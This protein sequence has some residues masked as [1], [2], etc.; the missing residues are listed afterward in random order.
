MIARA[1]R[2]RAPIDACGIG[3]RLDV[4]DDAPY[5]DCAY[6]LQEY[7]GIARRKQ[8]EG[9]ATWPGRKQVWRRV[10]DGRMAGDVV[11]LDS[12]PS[13]EGCVPLLQPVMRHGHRTSPAD[14]L[15]ACRDLASD[16]LK[17]L[18]ESLRSLKPCTP[19]RVEIADSIRQ[20]ASNAASATCSI[21]P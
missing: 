2:C 17:Q 8:S 21:R 15:A 1:V 13:P 18:P 12:D 19:Y 3:S 9:K 20:L 10:V 5:L 16:D 6:K 7:A 11:T 14:S 4:S